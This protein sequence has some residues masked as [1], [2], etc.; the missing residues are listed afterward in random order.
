MGLSQLKGVFSD[1]G[2]KCIKNVRLQKVILVNFNQKRLKDKIYLSSAIP[3][4]GKK[5][6]NQNLSKTGYSLLISI[7]KLKW[8]NAD[9]IFTENFHF[10]VS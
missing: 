6:C 2:E 4:G 8:G 1:G 3:S 10:W 7:P 5:E 9:N